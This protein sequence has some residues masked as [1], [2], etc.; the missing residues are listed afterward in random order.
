MVGESPRCRIFWSRLRR[1]RPPIEQPRG[2]SRATR[3]FK[4]ARASKAPWNPLRE[5]TRST[6]TAA[7]L[8]SGTIC[9]SRSPARV[10][11]KKCTDRVRFSRPPPTELQRHLAKWETGAEEAHRQ[12][13]SRPGAHRHGRPLRRVQGPRQRH[14]DRPGGV[15]R[16]GSR[17]R[18]RLSHLRVRRLR[19]GPPGHR[20][21]ATVTSR[22]AALVGEIFRLESG[23]LVAA[24][25]R[26]PGIVPAVALAAHARDDPAL[27]DGS[28][29]I[30]AGVRGCRGLS[31]APGRRPGGE[32]RGRAATP[33]APA[34]G[35]REPMDPLGRPPLP[36]EP[37]A[38][39][40]R[41]LTRRS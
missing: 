10:E 40:P 30:V 24:L 3:S 18:A 38:I 31:G 26:H 28:L 1:R 29:V 35:Q 7:R 41:S 37:V 6:Q 2:A 27:A 14:D 16:R 39:R 5:T 11:P 8:L 22:A 4:G 19:R 20:P 25:V 9:S 13:P 36:R 33:P 32:P 17:D 21:P 15:P 12:D 23:R 34:H